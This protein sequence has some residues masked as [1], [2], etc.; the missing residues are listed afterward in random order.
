M[1]FLRQTDL[2][3]FGS[4][5]INVGNYIFNDEMIRTWS[6][7]VGQ[8]TIWVGCSSFVA[9]RVSGLTRSDGSNYG[10]LHC[11]M[12]WSTDPVETYLSGDCP[13]QL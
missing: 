4:G 12:N 8:I 9:T 2:I 13:S 11:N 3:V 1:I 7:T 6:N 5:T 10:S